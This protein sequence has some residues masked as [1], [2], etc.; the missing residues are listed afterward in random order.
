MAVLLN[1]RQIVLSCQSHA[2]TD[3]SV[4]MVV[5]ATNRPSEARQ[6]LLENA[7]QIFYAEG[8]RSV[9]VDRL[10]TETGVTKATF[11]RHFPTKDHLVVAHVQWQDHLIRTAVE[12]GMTSL[13]AG[14]A[15]DAF[16]VG[17]A[18]QICGQ[19]FR[20]CPFIN[21]A[22]EYPDPTHPVRLAVEAHRAW[23]RDAF[24]ALLAADGHPEPATTAASLVL[25]RDGAMIGGY[26]DQSKA[27]QS[28]LHA[29]V[30]RLIAVGER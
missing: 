12:A 22:V 2:C 28:T 29:A 25:L 16:F 9:G 14:E 19:G 11:Y 15:I 30:G 1:G 17:L 21:A 23:L 24:T 10:V 13:S 7:S 27:V 6:R 20:G 3:R 5:V 4:S 18:G 26:L 8:I